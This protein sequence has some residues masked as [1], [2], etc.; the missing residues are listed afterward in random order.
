MLARGSNSAVAIAF[1]LCNL[2]ECYAMASGVNRDKERAE[3]IATELQN[4]QRL[5]IPL[6]SY[7]RQ[8]SVGGLYEKALTNRHVLNNWV[9]TYDPDKGTAPIPLGYIEAPYQLPWPKN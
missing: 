4:Y 5:T 8:L 6:F 3:E 1:S 7:Y 2:G 9:A